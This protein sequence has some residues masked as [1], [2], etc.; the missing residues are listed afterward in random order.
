M[1]ICQRYGDHMDGR[2]VSEEDGILTYFCYTC[3]AEWQEAS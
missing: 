2:C 1:T 3:G